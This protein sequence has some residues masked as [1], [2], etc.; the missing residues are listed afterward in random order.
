M[1][2]SSWTAHP[3]C[4]EHIKAELEVRVRSFP[5]S[6]LLISTFGEVFDNLDVCQ[7][8]LQGWAL[9]QGFVI[10]R[11]SGNVKTVRPRFEFR[12]IH[13]EVD[14]LN[15]RQLKEHVKRDEEN[16]IINRRK[17]EV[18]NINVRNCL[19]CIC[20]IYK[21]VDKRDSNVFDFV[22]S[23]RNNIHTHSMT[24]N[25]LRYKREYVKTFLEYLFVLKLDKLL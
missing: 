23:I 17:Q 19:Y 2:T 11:T 15:S 24:I 25:V 22:L 14:I 20:L 13:R 5:P 4:P 9:L 3:D 1:A 21:Q 12:C 18:T 6:F 10:V 16:R 8:R 7:E